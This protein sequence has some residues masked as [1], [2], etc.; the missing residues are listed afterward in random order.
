MSQGSLWLG[1]GKKPTGPG[2]LPHSGAALQP[3]GPG[4]GAS[5]RVPLEKENRDINCKGPLPILVLN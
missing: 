1:E 5:D 2:S 4:A 3:C